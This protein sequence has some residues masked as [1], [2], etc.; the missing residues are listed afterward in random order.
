MNRRQKRQLTKAL[1]NA[2]REAI[3]KVISDELMTVRKSAYKQAIK[4][5]TIVFTIALIDEFGFGKQRLIKL[6]TK[7]NNYFECILDDY[8]ALE[9]FQ[10]ELHKKGID[11]NEILEGR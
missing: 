6:L 2:N 1:I 5:L 11:I 9:D 10:Q 7:V 8:V 3:Y 4:D